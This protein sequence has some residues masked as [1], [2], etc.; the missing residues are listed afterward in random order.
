MF[1]SFVAS[2]LFL[3]L[4]GAAFSDEAACDQTMF[5]P[6]NAELFLRAEKAFITENDTSAATLSLARL[7]AKDLNC[8]ERAYTLRLF[9]TVDSPADMIVPEPVEVPLP[10]VELAPVP[11]PVSATVVEL[12]LTAPAQPD[13]A[14]A[15]TVSESEPG[16]EIVPELVSA[17]VPEDRDVEALTLPVPLYPLSAAAGRIEGDC[18]VHFDVSEQGVAR[19]IAATCDQDVFRVSAEQAISK[20]EFAPK[21]IEGAAVERLGAV[22][23][24][25]FRLKVRPAPA[26]KSD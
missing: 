2:G 26:P 14:T 20:T 25:S 13:L 24:V 7:L 11:E 18:D 12:E 9:K 15:E 8:F 21:L 23:P 3:A 16:P 17:P 19:N 1:K 6:D 22:Y 4:S 10:D 5:S